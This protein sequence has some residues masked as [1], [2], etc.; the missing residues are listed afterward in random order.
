MLQFQC[1]HCSGDMKVDRIGELVCPY[2][3]T[4]N[5]FTDKQLK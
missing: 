5:F 1:E 2:C 4:K 3:G